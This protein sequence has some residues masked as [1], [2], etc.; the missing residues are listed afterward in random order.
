MEAVPMKVSEAV[1][2]VCQE[3]TLQAKS[4]LVGATVFEK[5]L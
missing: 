3:P 2:R 5:G 4:G 1:E